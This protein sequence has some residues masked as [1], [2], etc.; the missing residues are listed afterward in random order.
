MAAVCLGPGAGLLPKPLGSSSIQNATA[1]LRPHSKCLAM[2]RSGFF[3]K[4]AMT[5]SRRSL[6]D[7][8]GFL[9]GPELNGL[10]LWQD[11]NGNGLSDPGEVSPVG[12]YGI[13]AIGCASRNHPNGVLWNPDGVQFSDGSVRPTYDYVAPSR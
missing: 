2:S 6:N 8:D 5:H 12:D 13:T 4:T 9:R 3:G 11:R 1:K 10:A 7:A